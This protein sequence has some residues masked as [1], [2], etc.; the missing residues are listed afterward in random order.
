MRLLIRL[1]LTIVLVTATMLGA[2]SLCHGAT[3]RI[4]NT[5]SVRTSA[6]HAL[7]PRKRL[8]ER[9]SAE[10]ERIHSNPMQPDRD[11]AAPAA[12]SYALVQPASRFDVSLNSDAIEGDGDVEGGS[13][14]LTAEE[15]RKLH[16]ISIRGDGASPT[17][18]RPM[19]NFGMT[20]FSGSLQRVL[21]GAGYT[22][23]TSIQAQS[24]PI[25]L[26]NRGMGY[27]GM[28]YCLPRKVASYIAF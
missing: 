23:P 25:A 12:A 13:P 20:P 2:F 1:A 6:L 5:R 7:S 11:S 16:Q 21:T 24:W 9:A 8:G 22:S 10:R 4:L 19:M 27:A 3:R 28:G 26:E 18:F 15:F 14:V 17:S